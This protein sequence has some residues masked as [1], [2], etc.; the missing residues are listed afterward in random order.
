MFCFW[1]PVSKINRKREI[2]VK[3]EGLGERTGKRTGREREE[4]RE[5]GRRSVQER[6]GVLIY[7]FN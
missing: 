3:K 2:N 1:L 6:I 7:F 4:N 5:R